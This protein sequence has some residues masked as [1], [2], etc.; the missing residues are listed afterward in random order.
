VLLLFDDPHGAVVTGLRLFPLTS[1][2]AMIMRLTVGGVPLW[3]PLLAA[4]LLVLR[5][6]LVVRAVA[7]MFHAQNL[8]SGQSFSARRFASALLGRA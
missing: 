2:I 1:P 8:L 4:G 5:A 6:I 3:Q 7:G